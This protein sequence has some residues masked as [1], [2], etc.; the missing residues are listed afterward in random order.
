MVAVARLFVLRRDPEGVACRY[1]HSTM[2][3]ANSEIDLSPP[4]LEFIWKVKQEKK[5]EKK[6]SLSRKWIFKRVCEEHSFRART[7]DFSN[8]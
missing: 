6:E 4:L 8:E 3:I 1:Y 5:K 7:I 2:T